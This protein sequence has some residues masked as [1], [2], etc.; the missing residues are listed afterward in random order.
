MMRRRRVMWLRSLTGVLRIN[1]EPRWVVAHGWLMCYP[2]LEGAATRHRPEL[3]RLRGQA[4]RL[5]L[6]ADERR[7]VTRANYLPVSAT[8]HVL[9]GMQHSVD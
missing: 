1:A 2:R 4:A 3:A 9:Y 8:R 7:V 6:S 5:E